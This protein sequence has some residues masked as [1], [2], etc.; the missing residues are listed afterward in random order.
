MCI[1][2]VINTMKYKCSHWMITNY[3]VRFYKKKVNCTNILVI[4][5]H[6]S[7]AKHFCCEHH[8]ITRVVFF[9]CVGQ[10]VTFPIYIFMEL[11]LCCLFATSALWL[12]TPTFLMINIAVF[13]L[14]HCLL[15]RWNI[16]VSFFIFLLVVCRNCY[17]YGWLSIRVGG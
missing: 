15:I 3:V 12:L 4:S 16:I 6:S 8:S 17:A 11:V 2:F 13:L 9:R 1:S 7:S 14:W 10:F 5:F